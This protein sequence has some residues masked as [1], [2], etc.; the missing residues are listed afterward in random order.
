MSEPIGR[1]E[2]KALGERHYFTGEPCKNGHVAVRYVQSGACYECIRQSTYN[3]RAKF[4][5]DQAADT[6]RPEVKRFV[7]ETIIVK[8]RVPQP[9]VPG[10]H[11]LVVGML[12]A[13]FPSLIGSERVVMDPAPVLTQAAGLT[14]VATFLI[15]RDDVDAVDQLCRGALRA[16]GIS[17]AQRNPTP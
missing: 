11:A 7:R 5:A 17:Q 12:A 13:H 8:H 6:L 14:V 3:I 2:A 10:I 1:T 4:A 16:F 9:Q 15:H